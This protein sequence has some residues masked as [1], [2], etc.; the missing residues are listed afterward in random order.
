MDFFL[1]LAVFFS[2]VVE[3]KDYKTPRGGGDGVWR[4][5]G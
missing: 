2:A 3:E 1:Y 4:G 5:G